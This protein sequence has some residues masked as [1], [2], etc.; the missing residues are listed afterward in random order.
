[1]RVPFTD[2]DTVVKLLLS[3][4]R[5]EKPSVL[6]SITGS[7][8]AMDLEPR[9]EHYII[10]GLER[11]ARSTRAWAITGGT[12]TGVMELA[13]EALKPRDTNIRYA[14]GAKWTTPLIGIAPLKKVTG[15]EALR[16][17]MPDRHA[18]PLLPYIKRVKNSGV[19]A[20]LDI[21]HSHF[22]LID[23]EENPEW[24]G[25]V[26]MRV[27][28]ETRLSRSL[29]CRLCWSSK[30]AAAPSRRSC[31]PSRTIVPLC[32]FARVKAARAPSPSSSRAFA[33]ARRPNHEEGR[34][35]L[36][37]K[38]DLYCPPV[39]A[40][41]AKKVNENLDEVVRLLVKAD[42]KAK[43]PRRAT[44]GSSCTSSRWRTFV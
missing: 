31:R 44:R 33:T 41:D 26:E 15:H 6:L 37:A 32:S 39:A 42:P 23:N 13:G 11:A 7:A 16:N 18:P 36:D 1:M 29:R 22:V 14:D 40:K 35:L 3:Y 9:L 43:E 5:I 2:A 19:S 21:N 28:I 17:A 24:G 12:D 25:E 4:W 30:A 8:Q 34:K 27:A 20:A 10:E 38:I